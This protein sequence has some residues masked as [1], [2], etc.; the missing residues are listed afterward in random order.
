MDEKCEFRAIMT[1]KRSLTVL[2]SMYFLEKPDTHISAKS[3]F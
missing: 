2:C 1:E 3:K